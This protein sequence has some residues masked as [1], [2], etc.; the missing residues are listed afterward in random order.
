[1]T[2]SRRQTAKSAGKRRERS[3]ARGSWMTSNSKSTKF[4][5]FG[6]ER[7]RYRGGVASGFGGM[8]A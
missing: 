6:I 8:M 5:I 4:Q 1:V 3:F 7:S 2:I